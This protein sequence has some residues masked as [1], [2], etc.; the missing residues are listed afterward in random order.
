M[1]TL[2]E[3]LPLL[4]DLLPKYRQLNSLYQKIAD[5]SILNFEEQCSITDFHNEF[6]DKQIFEKAVLNLLLSTDKGKQIQ[7]ISNLITE[8]SKSIDLYVT[9]KD[10]FDGIDTLRVCTKR[11]DPICTQIDS[12]QENANKL[13]Q[14]LTQVRNSLESASWKDD[15]IAIQRLT[16]DEERFEYLYKKEQEKLQILYESQKESDNHAIRYIDNQFGN[17]YELSQSFLHVINSYFPIEKEKTPEPESI[18]ID[19]EIISEPEPQSEIE[20]DMIFK[21]G[22]FNK[23][24]TLEKKLIEDKYLNPE[25]HWISVHGN[26]KS[27]IKRLV[28]FLAGLLDNRYFLPGRDPKIKTFFESRYHIT[29]GQ[30]FERK[31]RE[32]LLSEYKTVFYGYNF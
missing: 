7:I 10:F 5:N 29:I 15:K 19:T 2:N 13:W 16:Q 32:I 17:I 12:Q 30:N 1:E 31:R 6:K 20:P 21:T 3:H 4:I 27:D 23:L 9:H 24:L 22:M 11:H 28:M 8:I 25:L 14:E 18:T 26:G